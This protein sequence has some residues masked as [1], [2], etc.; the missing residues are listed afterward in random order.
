MSI[1]LASLLELIDRSPLLVL[2]SLYQVIS[3]PLVAGYDR[4]KKVLSFLVMLSPFESFM[5]EPDYIPGQ[6]QELY[7]IMEDFLLHLIMSPFFVVRIDRNN[8]PSLRHLF[9]GLF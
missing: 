6:K 4:G 2:G 8:L 5:E 1:D 7:H 9:L 3:R